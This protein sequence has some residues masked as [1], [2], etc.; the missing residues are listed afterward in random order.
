MAST[1]FELV[2]NEVDA[3]CEHGHDGDNYVPSIFALVEQGDISGIKRLLK[4]V[5]KNEVNA[6]WQPSGD[7]WISALQFATMMRKSE[8]VRL[9]LE[10]GA[11]ASHLS[12]HRCTALH[13]A[14][15]GNSINT[16]RE[17][18][19]RNE[20]GQFLYPPGDTVNQLMPQHRVRALIVAI[21]NESMDIVQALLDAGA[22]P[23]ACTPDGESPLHVAASKKLN[24]I[25]VTLLEAG[26]DPNLATPEGITA[27]H[28]ANT[29]RSAKVLIEAG[30]DLSVTIC[31]ENKH[32]YTVGATPLRTQVDAGNFEIVEEL[33]RHCTREQFYVKASDGKSALDAAFRP[34][35]PIISKVLTDALESLTKG[36]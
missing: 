35:N 22:D 33:S 13:Y 21:L 12:A 16:L 1:K 15:L 36:K 17:I 29:A 19:R 32:K 14:V 3:Y 5:N 6:I 20:N 9:L 30:I 24:D 34:Y 10:S 2:T 28:T 4:Y 23:N 27:I 26:A 11:D 31:R 7:K 25:V 8:V 18:L